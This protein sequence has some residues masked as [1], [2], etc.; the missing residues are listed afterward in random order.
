M[1]LHYTAGQLVTTHR[2]AT[3]HPG[4]HIH[5]GRRAWPNETISSEDWL[6]WFRRCLTTKIHV[7]DPPLGRKADP[8]YQRGLYQDADRIAQYTQRR[9][10]DPINSLGT[11]ELQR[12]FQWHYSTLDG[13]SITLH[14]PR[15][16]Q[17]EGK[18]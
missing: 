2:W 6:R 16:S 17:L 5:L 10:V 3:A 11:P 8:D 14:N 13:L 15:T 18:V 9:I 7:H 12:R 4:G 1:P